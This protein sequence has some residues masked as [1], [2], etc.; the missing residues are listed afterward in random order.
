MKL[1]FTAFLLLLCQ[2]SHATDTAKDSGEKQV[3]FDLQNVAVSQVINLMYLET[4][5]NPYILDPAVLKDDRITS[6]RFEGSRSEI[7]KLWSVFL[8]TLGFELVNK[9]GIDYIF[10]KK[11]QDKAE[12]DFV[13]FVYKPKHRQT[14]YLNNL[15]SALFKVGTFTA[16]RG[17]RSASQTKSDKSQGNMQAGANAFIDTDADTLIFL[18]PNDEVEKLKKVLPLVDTPAGEVNVKAVIYE[19][20]NSSNEGS[21][22]TLAANILSRRLGVTFGEPG[23]VQNTAF[24][25]AGSLE[26]VFSMLSGD[27]RFK[28]L[29]TPH[30]RIKNGATGRLTVG[31][32][33]P[34][35]GAI[36]YQANS[37]Q[38]VQSVEY[39]QSGVILDL[40]PSI[41]E[42]EIELK[43]DQQISDFAKTETGVNNSP[44]LTKRQLSTTVSAAS[45]DILILGGLTQDRDTNTR[46]GLPFIP[47]FF[48][49]TSGSKVNTEVLLLLEIVK[50]K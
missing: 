20:T 35:L 45:G 34:T 38:S 14:S 6:F 9:Y 46:S 32:D 2:L 29:S 47:S 5:K 44:T 27:S 48:H 40:V 50:I 36:Q 37:T 25:R 21:A 30:L 18:G 11:A 15:L 28:A 49:S 31:Q 3:R 4:L 42:S 12:E 1:L 39:R 26:A 8:E 33:V 13:P 24:I 16:N 7:G 41:R 10:L 19:V 22:F 23:M 43:I 17:I